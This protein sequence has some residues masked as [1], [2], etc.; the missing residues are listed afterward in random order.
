MAK[1]LVAK[2]GEQSS[3]IFWANSADFNM[4]P[5][6]SFAGEDEEA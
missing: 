2:Q 1:I 6:P 4:V 5:E 3:R